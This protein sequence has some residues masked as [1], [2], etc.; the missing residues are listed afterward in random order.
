MCENLKEELLASLLLLMK[1]KEPFTNSK[2]KIDDI[3]E[4]L[5]TNTKYLSQVINE[6]FG[7]NFHTFLNDYRCAK[8]I[9]L[10]H[11]PEYDDYSIEGI[12][13]T[14]GFNSRSSFVASFKNIQGNCLRIQKQLVF[15]KGKP[16]KGFFTNFSST[17]TSK[18][19]ATKAAKATAR[20]ASATREALP[21]ATMRAPCLTG[22]E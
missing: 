4:M 9:K 12:S 17:A 19:S 13:S 18:T 15:S 11:D 6:R 2:I 1:Q 20:T 22:K 21:A 10:F 14:C 7:K 5:N 16:I 8:V 3:A